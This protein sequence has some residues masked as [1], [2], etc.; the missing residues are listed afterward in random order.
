MVAAAVAIIRI[1]NMERQR[2]FEVA[3][4][5]PVTQAVPRIQ[6]SHRVVAGLDENKRVQ[7]TTVVYFALCCEFC[8][9]CTS[10]LHVCEYFESFETLNKL[11]K[12]HVRMN[13]LPRNHY[14][15]HRTCQELCAESVFS[16]VTLCS[17]S[18]PS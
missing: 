12:L 2:K 18:V 7:L 11:C 4:V 10:S 1:N 9:P 16:A 5:A 8:L 14:G 17:V 15:S 6:N 3:P 13:L